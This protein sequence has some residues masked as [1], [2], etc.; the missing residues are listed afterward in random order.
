MLTA[1][2]SQASQTAF[3]S[4][5][6]LVADAYVPLKGIYALKPYDGIYVEIYGVLGPKLH[7]VVG[8]EYAAD[9]DGHVVIEN[10]SLIRQRLDTDCIS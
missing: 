10:I 4:A 6:T 9:F 8:G 1:C 3:K 7:P 5:T 2:V